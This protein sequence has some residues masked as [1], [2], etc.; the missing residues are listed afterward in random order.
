[1]DPDCVHAVLFF[2]WKLPK[3][4]T[5]DPTGSTVCTV[6]ATR[7]LLREWKPASPPCFNKWLS[8]TVPVSIWRRLRSPHLTHTVNLWRYSIFGHAWIIICSFG[9]FLTF[10]LL[11]FIWRVYPRGACVYYP[12]FCC[13]FVFFVFLFILISKVWSK[14]FKKIVCIVLDGFWRC[15]QNVVKLP[16]AVCCVHGA[17]RVL[18]WV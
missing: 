3:T 16:C 15:R 17:W 6:T 18:I 8:H 5:W 2:F 4:A 14:T 11:C 9:Y 12:H 1:M 7:I 10:V 13:F